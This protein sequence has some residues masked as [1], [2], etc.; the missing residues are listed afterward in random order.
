M[1]GNPD[2]S[3]C[4]PGTSRMGPTDRIGALRARLLAS[5]HIDGIN[6][7]LVAPRDILESRGQSHGRGNPGQPCQASSSP[8]PRD[9]GYAQVPVAFGAGLY[10]TL[11]SGTTVTL[12]GAVMTSM[13]A[14]HPSA[15]WKL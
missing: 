13:Y 6:S 3:L 5:R 15:R 10:V 14:A 12:L 8:F 9:T 4:A 7:G 11:T 2:G 1:R